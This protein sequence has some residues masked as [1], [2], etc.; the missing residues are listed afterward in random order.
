MQLRYRDVRGPNFHGFL[1]RHRLSVIPVSPGSR[2]PSE[3]CIE[4]CTCFPP[5]FGLASLVLCRYVEGKIAEV[6][7]TWDC[8]LP[9][10][11]DLAH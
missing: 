10:H 2:V 3:R 4:K 11:L 7:T 1:S 9:V 8:V 5:S 6:G